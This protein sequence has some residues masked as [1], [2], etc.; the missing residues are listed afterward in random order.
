MYVT[1]HS[2]QYWPIKVVFNCQILLSEIPP[3]FILTC[4]SKEFQIRHVM[5]DGMWQINQVQF[6]W[7]KQINQRISMYLN[8]LTQFYYITCKLA[9][10]PMLSMHHVL[11]LF[12]TSAQSH[13]HC[14]CFHITLYMYREYLSSYNT[15]YYLPHGPL[16]CGSYRKL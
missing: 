2:N 7:C 9:A 4:R 15:L 6:T 3:Y 5:P 13:R 12:L 1:D 11:W 16:L 10:S 14:T 8:R